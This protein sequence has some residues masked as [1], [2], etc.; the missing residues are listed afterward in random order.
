MIKKKLNKMLFI[1]T[2]VCM[3][4]GA[5]VVWADIPDDIWKYTITT[6]EDNSL[7]C[8]FKEVEVLLPASW[9]GKT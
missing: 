4:S 9:T 1:L 2:S 5:G 3:L 6:Q 7:T 8:E